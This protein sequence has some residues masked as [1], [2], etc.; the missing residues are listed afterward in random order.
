MF[1]MSLQQEMCLESLTELFCVHTIDIHKDTS[2][3]PPTVKKKTKLKHP[4]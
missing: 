2:A 1:C 3:L 4:A